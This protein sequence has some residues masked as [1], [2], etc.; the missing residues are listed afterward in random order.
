MHY[1]PPDGCTSVLVPTGGPFEGMLLYT[2]PWLEPLTVPV[3]PGVRF[4]GTRLRPGA[5]E[6]VLGV[7]ASA[8]FNQ[9]LP[10]FH[11]GGP[12]G[13]R[14][15]TAFHAC[16]SATTD[17][18]GAA[19]ALDAFWQSE[20]DRFRTPD[21]VVQRAI[22]AMVRTNGEVAI[23]VI[24]RET[25]CSERTLL[26]R[27]R[28]A[29]ALSP[30]QF[31]RIRRLLAAAW[32]A[33]DGVEQWGRIAAA[34]GYADQPHLNHDVEALTGLRPEELS[35]RIALTEHDRVNRTLSGEV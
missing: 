3:T 23:A 20:R 33:V 5:T 18:D 24:A 6:A 27:F 1:V 25:G 10:A 4:V 19:G 21:V 32:H 15:Q 22:D 8:L 26:R 12:L 17:F 30:K 29:T 2:G 11:I 31:A 9:S 14:L 7:P 34:A 28:A 16:V 35:E 13:A